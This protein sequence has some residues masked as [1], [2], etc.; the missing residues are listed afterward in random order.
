M[1]SSIQSMSVGGPA[2]PFTLFGAKLAEQSFFLTICCN[3]VS[4]KTAEVFDMGKEC[5]CL[6][7]IQIIDFSCWT[8]ASR[9]AVLLVVWSLD[10]IQALEA[11]S[12]CCAGHRHVA[13][14]GELPEGVALELGVDM[15]RCCN[16]C[17]WPHGILGGSP[18]IFRDHWVANPDM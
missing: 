1:Y 3:I 8:A 9:H 11:K 10:P 15:M 6:C 12:K 14:I 17:S 16:S 5:N 2:P 4:I 7:N 18:F 13:F